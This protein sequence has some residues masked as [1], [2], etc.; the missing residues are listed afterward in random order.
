MSYGLYKY[1][2]AK[3][4]SGDTGSIEFR[5]ELWKKSYSGSTEQLEGAETYF[6]HNYT[7]IDSRNPFDKP[8]NDSALSMFFHVQ[9]SS[10]LALLTEIQNADEDEFLLKKKVAGSYD[11]QGKVVNDLLEYEE[12]DYPFVG[13]IT[14]KDLTYLKGQEYTLATG[15]EKIIITLADVLGDLGFGIGFKTHT[16]WVE[17]N[18]PDT[19]DDFLNQVYHD[20]F[21]F[22]KYATST[23]VDD[24]PITK[25]EVLERI[26]RNHQI[27]LR[28]VS[29]QWY[30]YQLSELSDPTSLN[31]FSYNSSGT[32]TG[33]ATQDITTD[34]DNSDLYSLPSGS[35]KINPAIKK[36]TVVFDHRTGTTEQFV[37]AV[38]LSSLTDPAI[39]NARFSMNFNGSGDEY[40]IVQGGTY[41]ICSRNYQFNNEEFPQSAYLLKSSQYYWIEEAQEWQEVADITTTKIG[42]AHV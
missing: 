17:N 41:A 7:K 21:A 42:R 25:Y 34:I 37:N 38:V 3:E 5:I 16:N 30:I 24:Q 11:W 27:I 39:P 36:A 6:E 4:L 35:N 10:H 28:Q 29:G 31:I 26:C 33:T 13:K 2:V 23:T 9:N 20:K 19:S 8:V 15:Y 14:A 32:Q 1:I 12:G 22:R 18:Q 40:V